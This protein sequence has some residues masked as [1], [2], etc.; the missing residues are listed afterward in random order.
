MSAITVP[1]RRGRIRRITLLLPALV[2]ALGVTIAVSV[3][4][5]AS[6]ATGEAH[7]CV[8]IGTLPNGNQAV[9]CSDIELQLVP[10]GVEVWGEGEYYCQG[11]DVQCNGIHANNNMTFIT[12][13]GFPPVVGTVQNNPYQCSTTACPN[14]APPNNRALVSTPHRFIINGECDNIV[15]TVSTGAAILPKGTSQA[16]HPGSNLSVTQTICGN[17]G[18]TV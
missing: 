15:A 13:S 7:S 10:D 9:V 12:V 4:Q 2:L 8:A 16:F 11:P 14:A 3:Q 18:I 17:S 6:A 1:F 5:P